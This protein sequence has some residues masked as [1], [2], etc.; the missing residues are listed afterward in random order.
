MA[1]AG[2]GMGALFALQGRINGQLG[3]EVGDGLLAAAI[4]FASGF[5]VL[6]LMMTRT[7]RIRD[8]LRR[9]RAA[10]RTGELRR[11]QCL[12]GI[13]GAALVASQAVTVGVLGVALFTVGVVV[14]QTVSGLIVDKIGLGPSGPQALTLTRVA[15]AVLALGGVAIALSGGIKATGGLGLLILPLLAGI[16]V[17]VQQAINGR[18]GVSAGNALTAGFVNFG[19]GSV[20]LVLA[21]ALAMIAVYGPPREVP[22]NPVLYLGGLIGIVFISAAAYLVRPLGVLLF[23][24]CTIA[25]QLI[26]SV[27][28]DLV[29]PIRGAHL[30]SSTVIGAAVTLL[31]VG[32]AS[33]PVR[34]RV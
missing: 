34:G 3:R 33:I 8:G 2:V 15:G 5:V 27:L 30:A 28:L 14:G 23:G 22:S 13:G 21:S 6:A 9:A 25:G 4:S 31:A 19:V 24:L 1:V 26:G 11:W 16:G 20:A 12:G 18:V 10:I 17:A 7:P 29:L 32:V